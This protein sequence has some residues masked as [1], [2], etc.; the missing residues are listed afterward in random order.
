MFADHTAVLQKGSWMH[1]PGSKG[2]GFRIGG[3]KWNKRYV[4]V[5]NNAIHYGGAPRKPEKSVPLN[6]LKAVRVCTEREIND[7]KGPSQFS[8]N[9]WRLSTRDKVIIFVAEQLSD[10]DAWVVGLNTFLHRAHNS[11]L[12]DDDEATYRQLQEESSRTFNDRRS[13]SVYSAANFD[14]DDVEQLFEEEDAVRPRIEEMFRRGLADFRT[15][16]YDEMDEAITAE[17]ASVMRSRSQSMAYMSR[18]PSVLRPDDEEDSNERQQQRAREESERQRVA[19]EQ[20]RQKETEDAEHQRALDEQ[21]RLEAAEE[22]ERQA[23][24]EEQRKQQEAEEAE[25]QRLAEEELK[26]RVAAHIQQCIEAQNS[27]ADLEATAR[28]SIDDEFT[29][30]QS[31]LSSHERRSHASVIAQEE[32][33]QAELAAAAKQL[34]EEA[35]FDLFGKETETR[36]QIEFGEE[37]D[38]AVILDARAVAFARA[39]KRERKR[40][41]D[42]R[43]AMEKR[44]VSEQREVSNEESSA[45]KDIVQDE[46]AICVGIRDSHNSSLQAIRIALAQQLQDENE[47]FEAAQA[48]DR[49]QFISREAAQ[50]GEQTAQ[51][52]TAFA[53]LV[54]SGA[55][56]HVDAT[57][58]GEAR[59][60]LEFERHQQQ[61]EADRQD[62]FDEEALERNETESEALDTFE[63]LASQVVA[64]E[65]SANAATVKRVAAEAEALRLQQHEACNQLFEEEAGQ[66]NNVSLDETKQWS[67]SVV[68][69]AQASR[70][71]AE[72]A[73]RDRVART[74]AEDK[75]SREAMTNDESTGRQ[76]LRN[77]EASARSTLNTAATKSKDQ[78][79]KRESH[80]KSL[81]VA[82]RLHEEHEEEEARLAHLAAQT[83]E[84][85]FLSRSLSI[86]WNAHYGIAN[87]VEKEISD[88][89]ALQISMDCG[90]DEANEA[91]SKRE[92]AVARFVSSEEDSRSELIAEEEE[93][94]GHLTEAQARD[95]QSA[96]SREDERVRQTKQFVSHSDQA[97]DELLAAEI[98]DRETLLAQADESVANVELVIA[99]RQQDAATVRLR[100]HEVERKSLARSEAEGRIEAEEEAE[101]E[102]TELTEAC[103]VGRDRIEVRVKA[104]HEAFSAQLN[105]LLEDERN[106]R[107]QS[108][109]TSEREERSALDHSFVS[110]TP[111]KANQQEAHITEAT[112]DLSTSSSPSPTRD[113]QPVTEQQHA[114]RAE[115]SSPGKTSSL[116]DE[117]PQ[118]RDDDRASVSSRG[119]SDTASTRNSMNRRS[120]A[121]TITM[122]QEAQEAAAKAQKAAEEQYHA[123]RAILEQ[124]VKKGCWMYKPGSSQTSGAS[125]RWFG[126]SKWNKRY[127]WVNGNAV[128]YGEKQEKPEKP[129]SFSSLR[130]VSLVSALDAERENCPKELRSFVWKLASIEKVIYFACQSERDRNNWIKYLEVHTKQQ[131]MESTIG[132][133]RSFAPSNSLQYEQSGWNVGEDYDGEDFE[134]DEEGEEEEGDDELVDPFDE[135]DALNNTTT[136]TAGGTN[137][138]VFVAH[139]AAVEHLDDDTELPQTFEGWCNLLQTEQAREREDLEEAEERHRA[140]LLRESKTVVVSARESTLSFDDCGATPS[141]SPQTSQQSQQR[142]QSNAGASGPAATSSS[143]GDNNSAPSSQAPSVTRRDRG[144]T[145]ARRD[146]AAQKR[147]DAAAAALAAETAE[148]ERIVTAGSWMYK[149]RSK[150]ATSSIMRSISS[151]GGSSWNK[152]FMWIDLKK[153]RILY[154]EKPGKPEKEVPLKAIQSIYALPP[155]VMKREGAPKNLWTL[156]FKIS[157]DD[158]TILWAATDSKIRKAFIDYLTPAAK[159]QPSGL[160]PRA[161]AYGSLN[162]DLDD[163]DLEDPFADDYD[164]EDYDPDYDEEARRDEEANQDNVGGPTTKKARNGGPRGSHQVSRSLAKEPVVPLMSM[165]M[166]LNQLNGFTHVSKE[167]GLIGVGVANGEGLLIQSAGEVNAHVAG[168]A[169]KISSIALALRN[170]DHKQRHGSQSPAAAPASHSTTQSPRPRAS[171]LSGGAGGGSMTSATSFG[172]KMAPLNILIEIEGPH[173]QVRT[174]SVGAASA[175]GDLVCVAVHQNPQR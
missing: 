102:F 30:V 127:V 117:P 132:S 131:D 56:E 38:I 33:R 125:S 114:T 170:G 98:R 23:A 74:A 64:G 39:Q 85:I 25:Q 171:T 91:T 44:F 160:Q 14:S 45:R 84:W 36:N 86:V 87:L 165:G 118:N 158:R 35:R 72:Q 80:R 142:N 29:A 128:L 43:Q 143:A 135:G 68:N 154:G 123:E 161:Q 122:R 26:Q 147:A 70:R 113:A 13:M 19:D 37:R 148:R 52:A 168:R 31:E 92:A 75:K 27:L 129:L 67:K 76:T 22:A 63:G 104:K 82:A 151:I 7:E 79:R 50:R 163:E 81:E 173:H 24:V 71:K 34:Q 133:V 175:T 51:E 10:R 48:E 162:N 101:N 94:A 88:F 139:G 58:R 1:K 32:Q 9:G 111:L 172:H 12:D 108:V 83:S 60:Q 95:Q 3:S 65:R 157:A 126:G 153:S 134:Y 57:Q 62:L 97:H 11:E 78:A 155:D 138:G 93:E 8:K 40:L 17:T 169:A 112:K 90:V 47:R 103:N 77:E 49:L 20:R 116:G 174:I 149:P 54:T 6:E 109:T 28:L 53:E 110:E 66:R 167:E 41:D 141:S 100:T 69:A 4:W 145:M 5:E 119:T 99:H 137:G 89:T 121:Q 130:K 115:E 150:S 140:R 159:R 106:A 21:R 55:Q 144:Q 146:E 156:G 166:F 164:D 61:L 15:K 136:S 124:F 107:S 2:S 18:S 96:H 16:F 152:R 46:I 59:I 73:T 105:A 120:R 42:E